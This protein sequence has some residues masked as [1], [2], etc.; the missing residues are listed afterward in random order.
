MNKKTVIIVFV[1]LLLVA[2][3]VIFYLFNSLS[4]TQ[5]EME[6]MVELMNYEKE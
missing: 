1:L 3:G 4:T 2:G 5:T 6:E